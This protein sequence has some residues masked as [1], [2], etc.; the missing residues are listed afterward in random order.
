MHVKDRTQRLNMRV[1][2]YYYHFKLHNLFKKRAEALIPLTSDD[3]WRTCF[4]MVG[5]FCFFS[6]WTL[7][8]KN[9]TRWGS[10]M[11]RWLWQ[12]L[13]SS[14]P[15]STHTHTHLPSLFISIIIIILRLSS[16][17]SSFIGSTSRGRVRRER[18]EVISCR[19]PQE[20]LRFR[21]EDGEMAA[22]NEQMWGSGNPT[23]SAF[24]TQ[25]PLDA[26]VGTN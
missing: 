4:A 16:S 14:A 12:R 22:A 2:Y 23:K 3:D 5:F 1:A 11:N 19:F 21:G 20:V 8:K 9:E 10:R 15:H 26:S 13:P 17:S 18:L 6:L 7:T 25:T 24:L